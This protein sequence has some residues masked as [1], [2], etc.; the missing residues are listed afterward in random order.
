MKII[1]TG[2]EP[3]GDIK[4]NP[5][6]QIVEALAKRRPPAGVH[7]TTKILP[8]TFAPAGEQI[9]TLIRAVNPDIVF[10]LGVAASRNSLNLERVALN[11]DDARLP[12]NAGTQPEGVHIESDGPPA[13]FCALPLTYLQGKLQ[14]KGHPTI[15]SNHAG[16]YV[17]NHV[18][19]VAAHMLAALGREA[20]S[21]FLHVPMP[22]APG[23]E[24]LTLPQMTDAAAYCLE[25]LAAFHAPG[26]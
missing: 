18:Y 20:H 14:A 11:L 24:G 17:C 8:V 19:Y 21:L 16:T 26:G 1:L 9:R 3:F 7:L 5:S 4:E 2:F 22:A 13:Y 25:L 12:D 6:Q 15:I 23:E 10:A